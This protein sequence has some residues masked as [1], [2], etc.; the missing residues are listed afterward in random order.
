MM[1]GVSE[2]QL[3]RILGDWQGGQVGGP[4]RAAAPGYARLAAAL[5][6]LL[7]DAR[8][9]SGARLPAERRLAAALGLSRTTV[10]AAYRLLREGGYLARRSGSGRV[11]APPPG[12]PRRAAAGEPALADGR[13]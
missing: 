10:A 7:L 2:N 1:G 13:G 5:R 6:A 3:T 8:V 12:P 9:P 11:T 4:G